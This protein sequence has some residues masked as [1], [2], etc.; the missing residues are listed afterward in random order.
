MESSPNDVGRK[1]SRGLGRP[2]GAAQKE[3]AAKKG[4]SVRPGSRFGVRRQREPKTLAQK[5]GER[6]LLRPGLALM[7]AISAKNAPVRRIGFFTGGFS[8]RS[9][10]DSRL[11]LLGSSGRRRTDRRRRSPRRCRFANPPPPCRRPL[12][13]PGFFRLWRSNDRRTCLQF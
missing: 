5:G 1:G 10:P 6:P 9:R 12:G 13:R 4:S 2:K 11:R 8:R 7:E 3:I